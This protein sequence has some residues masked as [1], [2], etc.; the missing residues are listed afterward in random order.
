MSVC[1]PKTDKPTAAL[2]T[3]VGENAA[4]TAET[5]GCQ[6]DLDNTEQK[7]F[8][9]AQLGEGTEDTI[10]ATNKIAGNSTV[11]E[12]RNRIPSL[13]PPDFWF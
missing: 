13:S 4:V 2:S 7:S 3:K 12:T 5:P 1:Y 8:H 9:P 6:G 10:R 11:W